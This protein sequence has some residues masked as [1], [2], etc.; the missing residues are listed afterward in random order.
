MYYMP[1]LEDLTTVSIVQGHLE[2][3][4]DT[5][6]QWNHNFYSSGRPP[7]E[8]VVPIAQIPPTN[9]NPAAFVAGRNGLFYHQTGDGYA[10]FWA[11]G[12]TPPGDYN[13]AAQFTEGEFAPRWIRIRF[14]VEANLRPGVYGFSEAEDRLDVLIRESESSGGGDRRRVNLS[15]RIL[16]LDG[17]EYLRDSNS[18]AGM[19]WGRW[20]IRRNVAVRSLVSSDDRIFREGMVWYFDFGTEAERAKRPT[21]ENITAAAGDGVGPPRSIRLRAFN[22]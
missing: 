3:Y 16:D 1:S 20:M 19:R 12:N 5:L 2:N 14:R 15:N 4:P 13:A 10:A 6:R 7:I 18:R 8:D 11:G 21:E 9:S 22:R 17:E